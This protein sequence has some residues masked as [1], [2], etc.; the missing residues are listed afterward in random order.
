MCASDRKEGWA[1]KNWCF[2]VVVLEKTHE[3]PLDTK[4]VKSVNPKGNQPWTFIGGTDVEA[5]TPILW[6]PDVK[7]WSLE[8]ALMLGKIEGRREGDDRGWDGWMA[9][10]TQW[11]SVWANSRRRWRTEEPGLLHSMGSKRVRH[12]LATE[13][14]QYFETHNYLFFSCSLNNFTFFLS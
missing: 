12:D 5:E 11:T 6:P 2:Q 4:E 13:Q 7:S 3:S 9:S 1:L 14:Q 10:P 8:K